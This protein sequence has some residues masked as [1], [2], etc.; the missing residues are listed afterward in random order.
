M[1]DDDGQSVTAEYVWHVIDA[2]SGLD[3]VVQVGPNHMLSGVLH[4]DRDD[5]VYVVVTPFDGLQYGSPSV[6]SALT[7]SNTAPDA[8]VVVLSPSNPMMGQDDLVC[9]VVVPSSDL[10]MDAMRYTYL[11]IDPTGQVAQSTSLTTAL[12]DVYPRYDT[13]EGD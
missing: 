4:F 10:D 5:S 13:I 2:V 9:T 1:S 3:A 12:S 7:V 6:S 11:W 8:P